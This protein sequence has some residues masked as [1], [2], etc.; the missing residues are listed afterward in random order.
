MKKILMILGVLL[1]VNPA[2]A[3]FGS[4][5][6]NNATNTAAL[7]TVNSQSLVS[8]NATRTYLK[9]TNSTDNDV[10]ISIGEAAVSGYGDF[11]TNA[12]DY[13]EFYGDKLTKEEI[14]AITPANSSIVGVTLNIVEGTRG[15]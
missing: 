1:V 6:F 9:I 4:N 5:T 12:G 15:N 10:Y 11:L 7:V 13:V 8:V 3:I 2:H 14:F